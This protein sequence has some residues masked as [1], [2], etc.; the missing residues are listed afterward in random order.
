M[1]VRKHRPFRPA[2]APSQK[3]NR[4]LTSVAIAT[5]LSERTT[6]T[7]LLEL[8]EQFLAAKAAKG[9]GTQDEVAK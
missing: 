8:E 9:S 4:D 5:L 3:G 6:I 1:E 2:H 7:A